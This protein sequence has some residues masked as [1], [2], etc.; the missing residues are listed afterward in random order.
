VLAI[1]TLVEIGLNW[2]EPRER[3]K[4]D[5]GRS[6][7]HQRHR[8]NRSGDRRLNAALH[9]IA[10]TRARCHAPTRTYTERRRAD[11]KNPREIRRCV[12][13]YLARHLYRLMENNAPQTR[14]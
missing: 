2:W 12:K 8:L 10:M 11:G 5:R 7:R 14:P 9:S 1:F 4:R 13:R 6:G 3:R